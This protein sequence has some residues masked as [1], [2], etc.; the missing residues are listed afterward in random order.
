MNIY[1]YIYIYPLPMWL[2]WLRHQTHK[3][4]DTGS[5]SATIKYVFTLYLEAI[6]Y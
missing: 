2:S 5:K 4:Y 1:I 3:Q 6:L